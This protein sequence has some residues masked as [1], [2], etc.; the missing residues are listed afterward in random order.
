[1]NMFYSFMLH[2]NNS[3][4]LSHATLLPAYSLRVSVWG[5]IGKFTKWF[6]ISGSHHMI[7]SV[8]LI[9]ILNCISLYILNTEIYFDNIR[10]KRNGVII[11]AACHSACHIIMGIMLEYG[12]YSCNMLC[13]CLQLIKT[14]FGEWATTFI[15]VETIV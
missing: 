1:M 14:T 5:R 15:H 2:D 8:S 7:T 10:N 4:I 13:R 11:L 9:G 3:R 12:A 6:L